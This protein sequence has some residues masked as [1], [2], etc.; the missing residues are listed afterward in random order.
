MLDQELGAFRAVLATLQVE[1]TA[2]QDRSAEALLAASNAKS[3]AVARA[4]RLEQERRALVEANP[5]S[6]PAA[7]SQ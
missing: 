3:E 4:V 2:L 6:M 1:R 7:A 5:G